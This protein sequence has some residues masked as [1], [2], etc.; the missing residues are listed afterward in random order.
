MSAQAP[1]R[2]PLAGPRPPAGLRAQR[3]PRLSYPMRFAVTVVALAWVVGL[4]LLAVNLTIRWTPRDVRF[5]HTPPAPAVTGPAPVT[6]T[7]APAQLRGEHEAPRRAPQSRPPVSREQPPAAGPPPASSPA[8]PAPD[9][10]DE[11]D[12][13]APDPPAPAEQGPA[14]GG[15]E[16]DAVVPPPP[17][18][19]GGQ[20]GGED[21]TG[22][23]TGGEDEAG[24]QG[25]EVIT[26]SKVGISAPAADER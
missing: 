1:Q 22:G 11:P 6:A 21:E 19:A 20:T 26:P 23:E 2:P 24:G 3:R 16:C 10:P 8:R 18:C 9:E 13:P 7:I 25:D 5:V 4:V 14:E 12:P 17:A 15:S